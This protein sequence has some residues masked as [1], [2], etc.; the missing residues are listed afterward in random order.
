MKGKAGGQ[1]ILPELLS[2]N[3]CHSSFGPLEGGAGHTV[4]L[5][6]TAPSPSPCVWLRV[7]KNPPWFLCPLVKH[8]VDFC[9]DPCLGRWRGRPE[10]WTE[11]TCV[12]KAVVGK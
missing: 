11:I 7:A 4:L 12:V 2:G 8:G 3:S 9:G 6:P 1:F 5:S 10:T